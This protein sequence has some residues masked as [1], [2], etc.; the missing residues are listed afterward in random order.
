[1]Y[2]V[3]SLD[4]YTG[5]MV[6]MYLIDCIILYSHDCMHAFFGVEEILTNILV[7]QTIIHIALKGEKL[8][9]TSN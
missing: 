7:L 6:Y 4:N 2:F 1:M 9:L 8:G 3:R 5:K